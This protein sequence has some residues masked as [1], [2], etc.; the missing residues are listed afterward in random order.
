MV[1]DNFDEDSL[2]HVGVTGMR[3]DRS[4]THAVS[5]SVR[6]RAEV[7]HAFGTGN[8][9]PQRGSVSADFAQLILSLRLRITDARPSV[10][11]QLDILLC[12]QYTCLCSRRQIRWWHV[13]RDVHQKRP[14]GSIEL[15]ASAAD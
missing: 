14:R 4:D 11:I 3:F 7:Q 13:N 1:G 12:P 8:P 9:K 6:L 15:R 5:F 2:T 10:D